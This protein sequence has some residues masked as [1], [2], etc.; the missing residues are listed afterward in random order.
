LHLFITSLGATNTDKSNS[1]PPQ[2]QGFGVW[3][4]DDPDIALEG[5]PS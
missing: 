1:L 3:E 4:P 5:L 2:G